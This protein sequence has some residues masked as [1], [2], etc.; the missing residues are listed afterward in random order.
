MNVCNNV[1]NG[2]DNVGNVIKNV[3]SNVESWFSF[4]KWKNI[5][6]N[7]VNG[8]K[9][10]FA[11]MRLSFK[12]PHFTWTSTPAQGWIANVLSALNLPTSLPKLNVNWYKSGGVFDSTSIIGVGEYTGAKSNPEIVAPQSMIYD[13]NIEAIRDSKQGVISSGYGSESIKKK[14][15]LELDLTSGGVKFGKKILD[16]ILD[17]NDFYDL[18]LL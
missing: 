7:A 5:A 17:A 18:G 14:V 15:Q 3:I 9:N 1:K 6:Q 16:L 13:A 12:L 11:N 10:T 8:I 4:E 2:F